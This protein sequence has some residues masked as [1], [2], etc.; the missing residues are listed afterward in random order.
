MDA[1]TETRRCPL[2]IRI[3][4][5]LSL[6]AN[7]AIVGLVA[8]FALRGGPMGG[9]TPAMGYAMPYVLALPRDLRRD[10][11]RAVRA[12]KDVPDRRARRAEYR[13]MIAAL[14]ASPFDPAAVQAVLGRQGE[15]ASRVQAVAQ[16]AWL[17]AV[18]RLSDGERMEYTA[19]MQ[20]ALNRGGRP[21]RPRDTP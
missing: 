1:E 11:F 15:G 10:V 3:A 13:Q 9:R 16:A 5:A 20:D 8:G 19:R 7:L 18:S 4:L 14:Q 21:K 6:A 17:E 2:W 12:G